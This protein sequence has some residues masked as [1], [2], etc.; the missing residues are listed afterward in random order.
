MLS[1]IRAYRQ[2]AQSAF[3]IRARTIDPFA[4]ALASDVVGEPET[5]GA[6]LLD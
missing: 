3:S 2:L 1:G 5:V 6:P 4:M